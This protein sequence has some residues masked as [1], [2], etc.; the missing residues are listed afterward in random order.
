MYGLSWILLAAEI[1]SWTSAG[2]PAGA[3][4]LPSGRSLAT[5]PGTVILAAA[6]GSE[7]AAPPVG[8]GVVSAAAVPGSTA[9]NI[10]MRANARS[11]FKAKTLFRRPTGLA[12][13]L[14]LKEPAPH[15]DAR[16]DSAQ[17]IGSPVSCPSARSSAWR[18]KLLDA[19]VM[20]PVSDRLKPLWLES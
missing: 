7:Y 1:A 9:P 11:D 8:A 17:L 13:G 10:S 18:G 20:C 16:R 12:D 15:T 19:A 3:A 2:A 4:A 5:S 14:A 6:V